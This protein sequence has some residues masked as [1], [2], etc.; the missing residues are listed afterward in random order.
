[1]NF[2][3][4]QQ[5]ALDH[6]LKMINIPE[7]YHFS[8]IM[9]GK[10]NGLHVLIF[11][12]TKDTNHPIGGEHYSFTITVDTHQ[13]LGTTWMDKRF[14][15]NSVL[16]SKERTKE[17]AKEYLAKVEPT[18]FAKLNNLWIEAHDEIII[19]NNEEVIITGMKYKCFIPEEDT[20]AWVIVGSDE[21]V[22][23]FERGIIWQD[24]RV[25]EKWLHDSWLRGQ[26]K[27]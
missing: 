20:Y 9:E 3:S 15:K 22:I 24:G 26:I 17:I 14:K 4:E 1:M 13:L 23:T 25:T 7:E 2:T 8:Q 10:Q 27:K 11:R 18:L 21:N 16:P 19:A 12:Y 5:L 6:T